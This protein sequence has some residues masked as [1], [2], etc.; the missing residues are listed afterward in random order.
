MYQ[1]PPSVPVWTMR[2]W[3]AAIVGGAL[4][5]GIAMAIIVAAG[6]VLSAGLRGIAMGVGQVLILS[7]GMRRARPRP[8]QRKINKPAAIFFVFIG[9]ASFAYLIG[10]DLSEGRVIGDRMS[11]TLG[12]LGMV[13]GAYPVRA[14]FR[15]QVE[16]TAA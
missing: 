4:G 8:P 5:A 12:I 2:H 10:K 13:F 9:V 3:I 14:R 7:L 15:Q 1:S 16:R 11:M 6:G